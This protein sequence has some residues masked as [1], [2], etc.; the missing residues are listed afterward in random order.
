[1]NIDKRVDIIDSLL[2]ARAAAGLIK[3]TPEQF[4]RADID[5]SNSISILDSQWIAR[6]AANAKLAFPAPPGS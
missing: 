5:Y 4:K 1:M 2:V 6:K 3:F